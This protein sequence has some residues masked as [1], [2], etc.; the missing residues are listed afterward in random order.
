MI[1]AKHWIEQQLDYKNQRILEL[2]Q[3][4]KE[5]EKAEAFKDDRIA[6]MEMWIRELEKEKG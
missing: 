1:E 5:L 3:W 2:E 4:T 6:K